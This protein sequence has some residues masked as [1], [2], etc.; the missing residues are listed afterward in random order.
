MGKWNELTKANEEKISVNY[1]NE[2]LKTAK[3]EGDKVDQIN[4]LL[5]KVLSEDEK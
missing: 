3:V 2:I 1:L 4:K 5:K